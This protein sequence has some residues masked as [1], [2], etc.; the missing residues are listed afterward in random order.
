MLSP[1]GGGGDPLFVPGNERRR[2]LGDET[3][4]TGDKDADAIALGVE[5]V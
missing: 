4:I 2:L 3:A 1:G 5:D